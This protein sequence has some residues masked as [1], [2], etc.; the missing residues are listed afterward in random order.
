MR[1]TVLLATGGALALALALALAVSANADK[2]PKPGKPVAPYACPAITVGY[3]ATG[4]LVKAG[5]SLTAVG[6]HRYTGTIEVNVTRADHR[7][8]TGDQT[9]TLTGARVMFHHRLTAATLADGDRVGLHGGTTAL[10]KHC[11]T[12]AFKPMIT[13]EKVDINQPRKPKH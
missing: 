11:S 6:R 13:I 5:T 10:P 1:R 8:A 4:S 9:F 12:A 7:A 3:N 2:P